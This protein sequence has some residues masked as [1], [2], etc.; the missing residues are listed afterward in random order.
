MMRDVITIPDQK[1]H[2][3]CIENSTLQMALDIHITQTV[4]SIAFTS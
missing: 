3:S 2:Q 1:I 4:I